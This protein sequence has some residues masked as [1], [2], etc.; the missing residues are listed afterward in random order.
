M[1][2]DVAPSPAA[3]IEEPKT[4]APTE[5]DPPAVYQDAA[6]DSDDQHRR[7]SDGIQEALA[8]LTL[9]ESV[10]AE[11][12]K[13][14]P[15]VKLEPDDDSVTF[16]KPD[17]TT[18]KLIDSGIKRIASRALDAN[19][20]RKL[21]AVIEKIDVGDDVWDKS[22]R[23]DELLTS[24]NSYIEIPKASLENEAACFLKVHDLKGMALQTIR[25]LFDR[26]LFSYG[27]GLPGT[28]RSLLI[29]RRYYRYNC[30]MTRSIE[31][32]AAKLYDCAGS[33][34]DLINACLVIL[35]DTMDRD[36]LAE[37][38]EGSG[39]IIM[40]VRG[41][42]RLMERS[43]K[44]G[45]DSVTAELHERIGKR[46]LTFLNDENPQVRRA[47]IF[48]CIEFHKLVGEYRFWVLVDPE[49]VMDGEVKAILG[50]V[51]ATAHQEAVAAAS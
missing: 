5:S 21:Q 8:E 31:R 9:N 30:E 28:I 13:S 24:L 50:R 14:A 15:A 43:M 36:E 17:D 22:L 16:I 10:V 35:L 46:I 33:D 26:C 2:V 6:Y 51:T 41:C 25:T 38:P 12:E 40:A 23:F 47:A 37:R 7:I 20:Y 18:R 49:A 48:Y 45:N 11:A 42:G 1:E 29:M 44:Y 27:A 19:G 32:T 39:L 34:P 4:L 3:P